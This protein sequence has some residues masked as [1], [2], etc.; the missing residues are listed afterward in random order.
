ML[1]HSREHRESALLCSTFSLC[2]ICALADRF[3]LHRSDE[4][5]G[6]LVFEIIIFL[7]PLFVY[8]SLSDKNLSARTVAKEMNI[9]KISHRLIFLPIFA[10]MLLVTGTLLLDML[11]FGIYDI[12]GGFTLYGHLTANSDGSLVST[13]LMIVT[14]ALLPAIF[15]EVMFRKLM[16]RTYAKKGL[17]SAMLISGIFFSLTP[18][19]LRLIPSFFLAGMIYC[20]IFIVTGSLLTSIIA[21]FLFNMYGLFLRT[22]IANYF[23]ASADVYVL[24]ISTIILFLISALLFAGIL[25]KLFVAYAKAGKTPPYLPDTKKGFSASVKSAFS[26][27]KI[28]ANLACIIIYAVF[29]VVFAFLG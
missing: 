11:F 9:S 25:S 20:L 21:H 24:V 4:I 16:T 26:I 10:A 5:L 19:S 12:T 15:E 7:I 6:S 22:N 8:F 14:F 28:P 13:I 23:V 27:F 2:L 29:I 3:L 1:N 18:F 17:F